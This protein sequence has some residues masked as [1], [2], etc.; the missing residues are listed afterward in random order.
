M[1]TEPVHQQGGEASGVEAVAAEVAVE[2]M[3]EGEHNN[4]LLI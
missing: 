1:R 3:D 4:Y 2:M